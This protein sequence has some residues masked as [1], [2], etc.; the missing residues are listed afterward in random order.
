MK[1]SSPELRHKSDSG[2]VLIDVQGLAA[3]LAVTEG[4]AVVE[5]NPVIAG[6]NGVIV[7][8]ALIQR[9]RWPE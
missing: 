5:L 9:E 2:A 3:A 7:V 6:P 4:L 1:L 8:D